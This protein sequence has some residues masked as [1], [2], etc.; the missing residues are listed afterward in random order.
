MGFAQ[1]ARFDLFDLGALDG[2]MTRG[3]VHRGF[4]RSTKLLQ[5][6]RGLLCEREGALQYS[7]VDGV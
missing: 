4:S 1:L 6:F 3:P 5:R 7:I 2:L